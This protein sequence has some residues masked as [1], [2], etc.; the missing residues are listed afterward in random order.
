MGDVVDIRGAPVRN[1]TIDVAQL[2]N[3]TV[4][5][6]AGLI[7]PAKEHFETEIAADHTSEPIK[8]MED[9]D[10]ICDYLRKR[11]R[12][13]DYMLFVVGINFGLRVSDLTQLRFCNLIND[14]LTFKDTFPVF[15]QKTR[16]TRK[17][18]K[19][20]YITINRAVIDAVTLYLEHTPDVSLSDYM[21]RSQSPNGS[22]LNKP[23]TR[24]SV[25]V[26]LKGLAKE[27]NLTMKVS[28]HTLRK[29]FAYH[30][31][32]MSHNDPRKLALL[33]KMLGHSSLGVTMEYIGITGEE[34]EEAYRNLN[35]GSAEH[36]YMNSDIIES[37]LLAV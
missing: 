30:Q 36:N 37:E 20:R 21:F 16:N 1:P 31:M 26:M 34:I 13:R 23:I 22:N 3:Q 35:L 33:S 28:T 25:D 24:C 27:L 15:E 11:R 10:R 18:K 9:I 29:T 4:K 17:R 32:V 7:A 6:K 5:L 14:N 19:N 2:K 8:N 12:W